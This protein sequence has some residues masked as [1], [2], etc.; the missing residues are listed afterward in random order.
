AQ[1][2]DRPASGAA[3]AAIRSPSTR[4]SAV[5]VPVDDT[6][7]PPRIRVLIHILRLRRGRSRGGQRVVR[8]RPPVPVEGPQV[9]YLGEGAHVEVTDHDLLFGVGGDVADELAARV[10][11]VGLAVELVVTQRLHADPVD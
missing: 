3:S 5:W 7:V 9:A 8:V 6:T 10:D 2:S 11:E 4:T 1:A